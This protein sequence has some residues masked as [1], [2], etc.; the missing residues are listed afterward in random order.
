MIKMEDVSPQLWQQIEQICNNGDDRV[1]YRMRHLLKGSQAQPHMMNRRES[2]ISNAGAQMMKR[3]SS[4]GTPQ[5]STPK[6]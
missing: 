2:S 6:V 4:M 1:Q 3:D 5:H